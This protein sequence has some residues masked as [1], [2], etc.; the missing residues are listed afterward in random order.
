MI[1]ILKVNPA[2]Y[3]GNL[4]EFPTAP[5]CAICQSEDVCFLTGINYTVWQPKSHYGYL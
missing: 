4:Q 3:S 2:G 1:V 5:R